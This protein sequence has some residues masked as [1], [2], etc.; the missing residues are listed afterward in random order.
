MISPPATPTPSRH[1]LNERLDQG[2]ANRHGQDIAPWAD[3]P[4]ETANPNEG[5]G[6]AQPAR[7]A[8]RSG[9]RR[10]PFARPAGWDT[11]QDGMPD[12][13]GDRSRPQPNVANNNDDFDSDLYTDLEEYLNDIAA[14]PAPGTIYFT[15]EETIATHASSTGGSTAMPVNVTGIGNVHHLL[16]L[17]AQPL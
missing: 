2:T 17:A 1:A 14:W 4:Y 15:G 9:W 3:D 13:L 12:V 7:A 16:P 6:M 5:V 8:R 11:D 10:A